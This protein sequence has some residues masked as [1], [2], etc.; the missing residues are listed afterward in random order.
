MLARCESYIYT[1]E[2]DISGKIIDLDLGEYEVIPSA[3]SLPPFIIETP[4]P[5]YEY[6]ANGYVLN[7]ERELNNLLYNLTGIPQIVHYE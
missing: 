1:N 3:R 7:Y 6:D 4:L 5:M 2:T